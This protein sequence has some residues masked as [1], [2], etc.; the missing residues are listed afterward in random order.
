MLSGANFSTIA[1]WSPDAS[2]SQSLGHLLSRLF[3][4]ALHSFFFSVLQD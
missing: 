2:V 4:P 3:C 1:F